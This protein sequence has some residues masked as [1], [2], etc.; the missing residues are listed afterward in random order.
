MKFKIT[1]NWIVIISYLCE[2]GERLILWHE[3]IFIFSVYKYYY[4]K[5]INYTGQNIFVD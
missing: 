5:I 2:K 3:V 4:I 1:I